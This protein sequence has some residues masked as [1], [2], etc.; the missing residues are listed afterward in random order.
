MKLKK[1]ALMKKRMIESHQ[2]SI[3]NNSNG[4]VWPPLLVQVV[5]LSV[6]LLADRHRYLLLDIQ[7]VDYLNSHQQQPWVNDLRLSFNLQ[8]NEV[9][10]EEEF[11][12]KEQS[13]LPLQKPLMM[14]MI[15]SIAV[16][17]ERMEMVR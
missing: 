4:F 2:Y 17:V 6:V 7:E 13:Q 10:P 5:L 8:K 12:V 16:H 9:E 11:Q 15:Y 3:N 14:R 1:A